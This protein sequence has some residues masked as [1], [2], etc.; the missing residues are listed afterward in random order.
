MRKIEI[1]AVLIISILG[2]QSKI[3]KK[4]GEE[5]L[6]EDFK[7]FKQIFEKANAGLYKYHSKEEIDSVFAVNQQKITDST[8][9]RMFY[10]LLYNVI[11]YSGSSHNA[12]LPDDKTDRAISNQKI[13]FP[14]PLKYL[15]GKLYANSANGEIPLGS[16]ITAVNHIN[17]DEFAKNVS[18]YTSTDGH[19]Q[20]GKYAFLQTDWMPYFV[21][22]AYGEQKEFL[23]EYLVEGSPKKVTVKPVTYKK[24]YQNNEGKFKPDYEKYKN[25]Y[26]FKTLDSITAILRVSTF[27]MGGPKS[28]EHKKYATFLDS[29]FTELKKDKIRNL[30]V[31]IRGN[32]GGN[33]PN[34]ILLYSYLT[35]RDFRENKEAFVLVNDHIPLSDYFVGGS[36]EEIQEM[37]GEL[38]REHSIFKDG[39]YY[40]NENYNKVWSP[41]PKTFQGEIYLLIDPFVASAGS[42]FA[43]MV[44]SDS[45]STVIGQETLGGYYGHT[46]HIPVTYQL[47]NTKLYLQFSIVDLKQDVRSLPDEKWGEGV[48]P[49][50]FIQPTKSTYL[51]NRDTIMS[52]TKQLIRKNQRNKH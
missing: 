8:S 23:I 35:K 1:L 38:Q 10:N 14:I 3:D 29:V 2:C 41:N 12:L 42:L 51:N 34:D 7:I 48:K 30:I 17:A 24:F 39:K 40:Q 22:L 21:Y 33:D 45:T 50:I 13:F 26:A 11:D 9:F 6:N 28:E 16:E 25:A 4:F 20:T 19:N 5:K 18:K 31:D 15:N 46:G 36:E 27:G 47:P 43:S 49:D 44:K 32:G 52:F 37:L